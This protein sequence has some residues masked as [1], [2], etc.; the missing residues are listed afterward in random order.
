[1]LDDFVPDFLGGGLHIQT[2]Y[3]PLGNLLMQ[4][5]SRAACARTKKCCVGRCPASRARA[6][7]ERE[8]LSEG[9][10][11]ACVDMN[12]NTGYCKTNDSKLPG[13]NSMSLI[14]TCQDF[15]S[16]VEMTQVGFFRGAEASCRDWR[17]AHGG[18]TP[19]FI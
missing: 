10:G 7:G 6:L 16:A 18:A 14:L 19:W 2:L 1:M 4:T 15:A 5:A 3:G 12:R 9:T 8:R 11:G 13:F 17:G